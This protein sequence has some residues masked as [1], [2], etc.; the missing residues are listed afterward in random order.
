MSRFN[1]KNE[2]IKKEYYECRSQVNRLCADSVSNSKASLVRFEKFTKFKDFSSFNKD[3]AIC[4]KK[5]LATANSKVTNK[6]LGLSTVNTVL[7]EVKDF[8]VWLVCQRGYRRLIKTDVAYF[9][10]SHKDKRRA[11]AKRHRPIPTF[12]QIN[13][14]LSRMP[15]KTDIE[16]RNRA[17]IAFTALT[18]VR[19]GALPSLRLKHIR[20]E[21]CLVEQLGSEV[22]TKNSKTIHTYFYPVGEG[23]RKIVLDWLNHLRGKLLFGNDDPV[24]PRTRM[25]LGNDGLFT[26]DGL[27]RA[28]WKSAGPIRKIFKDAFVGAELPYYSPH[29]FRFTIVQ[30]GQRMCKSFEQMKA[31]SQN[32]GHESLDTTARSYGTIDTYSQGE[33][34]GKLWANNDINPQK[35]S[36]ADLIAEM[37]IAKMVARGLLRPDLNDKTED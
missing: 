30:L 22:N 15:S 34:I 31:W 21:E 33:I 14:V 23:I 17:L 18:G 13:A 6:P 28:A 5:H 24:F 4:F 8:F 10:L 35:P 3:Q 20:L 1:S 19:D 7:G 11:S 29:T 26:P 27:E 9:N 25:V 2:R 32:L 12:Q 37:L 36:D 16:L